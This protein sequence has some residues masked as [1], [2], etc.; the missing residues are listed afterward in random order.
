MAELEFWSDGGHDEEIIKL[1]R[2]TMGSSLGWASK[3]QAEPGRWA[4]DLALRTRAGYELKK[5]K[6]VWVR[7]DPLFF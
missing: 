1:N 6:K 7:F 4:F 3:A 5:R 2:L